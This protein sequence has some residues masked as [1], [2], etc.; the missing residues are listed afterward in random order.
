MIVVSLIQIH[1]LVCPHPL[2]PQ[3]RQPRRRL[4]HR[5][6]QYMVC[7]VGV[8]YPGWVGAEP[9]PFVFFLIKETKMRFCLNRVKPLKF[10]AAWM[11][12]LVFLVFSCVTGFSSGSIY[13]FIDKPMV[14]TELLG[15]GLKLYPSNMQCSL[16]RTL[17][18]FMQSVFLNNTPSERKPLVRAECLVY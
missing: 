1:P 16:N 9:P 4:Q 10:A 13:S 5:E 6:D 2:P 17:T 11:S 12:T 14:T 7:I 18:P 8:E 15:L 3:V